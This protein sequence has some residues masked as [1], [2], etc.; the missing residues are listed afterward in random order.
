MV[1]G[2]LW[3]LV[4]R[5]QIDAVAHLAT[6]PLNHCPFC[7]YSLENAKED[8]CPECGRRPKADTDHLREIMG[9]PAAS[10]NATHK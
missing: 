8:M 2:A 5:W 10:S 3:Y 6:K 4:R 7:N 1:I 9:I